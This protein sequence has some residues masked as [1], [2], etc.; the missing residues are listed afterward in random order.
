MPEDMGVT[1]T[2]KQGDNLI[3]GSHSPVEIAITVA[4]G[5]G[6][7]TAGTLLGRV[8]ASGKYLPYNAAH[9]DGTE[10]PRAIL[11]RDIDAA[12]ADA[13]VT[14]YVHGEFNPDEI[15]GIDAAAI[16][17]LQDIGIYIKEVK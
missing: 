6:A 14:V 16:L 2:T 15:T 8:T 13:R 1:K 3:A 10:I 11:T 12:S 9:I 17:H 7:L 5:A 4:S